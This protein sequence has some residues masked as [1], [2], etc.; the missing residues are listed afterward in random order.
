MATRITK[1]N[2]SKK[3]FEQSIK[4]RLFKPVYV[5]EGEDTYLIEHSIDFIKSELVPDN[6]DFNFEV[7]FGDDQ[8]L[9]AAN[10]INAAETM[11]LFGGTHVIIIRHANELPSTDLEQLANYSI[12]V[13]KSEVKDLLLILQCDV[14]DNRIKFTKLISDLNITVDFSAPDISDP[15]IIVSKLFNKKIN[16]DAAILFTNIVGEAYSTVYNELNK[17]TAYI[18]ERKVITLQDVLDI[19][20]GGD[21]YEE[22]NLT[23][24]LLERN[25]SKIYDT[26][27]RMRNRKM[28][29]LVEFSAIANLFINLPIAKQ[30]LNNG[31]NSFE[32]IRLLRL[33]NASQ[34]F[35]NRISNYLD[36]FNSSKLREILMLVMYSE[37]AL[38]S[39]GL[40]KQTINDIIFSRVMEKG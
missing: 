2:I 26:I 29:P 5:F 36:N 33:W 10:I 1:K 18:G 31:A 8:N 14:L 25:S 4:A 15:K 23:L 3:E 20:A 28:D 6:I 30:L 37:I 35:K 21:I 9:S 40:S 12:R 19:C 27:S 32:C 17:L 7:L 11:P 16:D 34:Q 39:T 22:N 13:L 24:Y 38:K